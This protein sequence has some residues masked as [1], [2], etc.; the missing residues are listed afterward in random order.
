MRCE[1]GIVK[2]RTCL[3]LLKLDNI[4]CLHKQI[5]GDIEMRELVKKWRE[6]AVIEENKAKELYELF[7]KNVTVLAR[8]HSLKLASVYLK[9]A[10]E[11]EKILDSEDFSK[12]V[13]E[14]LCLSIEE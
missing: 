6:R 8:D 1:G 14:S 2:D 3:P 5:K 10:K 9:C 12:L 11:V 7:G 13:Y 4:C